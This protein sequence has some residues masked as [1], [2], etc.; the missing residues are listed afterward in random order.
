MNVNPKCS[1]NKSVIISF[2]QV[3]TGER[4]AEKFSFRPRRQSQEP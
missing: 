4:D 3:F 2:Y 1:I